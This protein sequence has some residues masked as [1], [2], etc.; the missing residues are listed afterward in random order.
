MKGWI[1]MIAKRVPDPRGLRML[2]AV[3]ML[4]ACSTTAPALASEGTPAPD[5]T[6]VESTAGTA[7]LGDS[8]AVVA[9]TPAMNAQIVV[10]S[11]RVRL[12]GAARN[13]VR[14]GPGDSFAVVGVYKGD[15]EFPVF[16]K[17]GDWYGVKLSETETGWVHHSL[18]KEL[19]DMEGLEFKPNPRLYS[20]TG[21]FL[22]QGYAGGYAFDQKSNSFVAGGRL[23]YYVFDRVIVEGGVSWTH[24][25]RPA[26]IVESL[27]NLSLEAEDFQMLSY[28]FMATYEFLPGRQM[29]PY[30][31]AGMGSSIMEGESEP[32]WNFG[33]G[34]TVYLSR[35]TAVRW[36]VRLF[37]F[38]TGAANARRPHDNVELTL[39][40]LYLF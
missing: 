20:R 38:E 15:T 17:S 26:E 24:V 21:A 18:C 5:S 22:I 29:V 37:H 13:V 19:D 31:S 30:V 35:R 36:E 40:S 27:F 7:P 39:G 12:I 33:A 9:K 6:A 4:G 14:S 3:V 34:T 11:R 10:G 16:A 2:I 8:V 23:G 28:Q 1:L 32:S 25:Y